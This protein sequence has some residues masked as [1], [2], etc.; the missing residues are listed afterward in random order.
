MMLYADKPIPLYK[1][2]Y[3]QLHTQ[4][5]NGDYQVGEKLPSVREL[6][7]NYGINR[8]T[9]RRAIELLEQ[10]G[11]VVVQHGR[12]VFVLPINESIGPVARESLAVLIGTTTGVTPVQR[13]TGIDVVV[14]DEALAKRLKIRPGDKVIRLEQVRFA[15]DIPVSFDVSWLPADLCEIETCDISNA[16]MEGMVE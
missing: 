10:D 13:I 5:E 15:D 11:Y 12:G 14:A 2:L 1:Q 9:A 4:I 3:H 16:S 6:A 7:A 8:L